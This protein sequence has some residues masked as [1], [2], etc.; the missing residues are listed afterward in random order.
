MIARGIRGR[1]EQF[2][3]GA[4]LFRSP[5][6]RVAQCDIEQVV[7]AGNTPGAGTLDTASAVKRVFIVGDRNL[8]LTLRAEGVHL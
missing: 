7:G 1:K 8:F 5:L 4:A 6:Q 3:I 2:G